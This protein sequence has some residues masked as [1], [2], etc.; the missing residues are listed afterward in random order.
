MLENGEP[1]RW[2]RIVALVASLAAL[3]VAIAYALFA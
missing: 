3:I 1:K 2:E